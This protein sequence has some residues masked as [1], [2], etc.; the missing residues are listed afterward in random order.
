M[1]FNIKKLFF[2]WFLFLAVYL[3]SKL[4]FSIP[5]LFDYV[6]FSFLIAYLSFLFF[7]FLFLLTKSFIYSEKIKKIKI[8]WPSIVFALFFSFLFLFLVF[9]SSLYFRALIGN[10]LFLS[11]DLE[12]EVLNL[13]NGENFSI[14]SSFGVITNPFCSSDC[15]I[16][17]VD[18]NS[19]EK[20]F[21]EDKKFIFSSHEKQS[22]NLDFSDTKYG[23]RL[24]R[25]EFSCATKKNFLCH[26]KN[27]EEKFV[28]RV[29]V[30][31]H[32]LNDEQKVLFNDLNDTLYSLNEKYLFLSSILKNLNEIKS[33]SLNL[34]SN[35]LRIENFSKDLEQNNLS[36]ENYLFS[37][38]EFFLLEHSLTKKYSSLREI[39]IKI[40]ELNRSLNDEILKYNFL[41]NN[42][43]SVFDE[44]KE[45]S[46]SGVDFSSLSSLDSLIKS[47]NDSV[48]SFFNFSS[49][50]EKEKVFLDFYKFKQNLS[51]VYN[52]TNPAFSQNIL[53]EPNFTI[54]NFSLENYNFSFN[55]DSPKPLC[56]AFEKCV[57]CG[58][59]NSSSN[60]PVVF[61]HGHGFNSDVSVLSS[62][63][64]F[65]K[66]Q[67]ELEEYGY[68]N[69]GNFIYS[70]FDEE[71][72]GIFGNMNF[73]VTF[74]VSYYLLPNDDENFL[75]NPSLA[76]A[77]EY[78]IR[79]NKYIEKIKLLTG[80]D[81]VVLVSYSLGGLVS[82]RYLQ[83]F[84]EDSVDRLI[85]LA[86]PNYGVE[87][88][89]DKSC[90]I[91]GAD[92]ECKDLSFGSN[93]LEKL[94]SNV[95]PKIPVYNIL[96]E[97]CLLDGSPSDGIVKTKNSFL[98]FAV[99]R[100]FRG[101]CEGVNFLHE[102]V[103]DPDLIPEG[104]NLVKEFLE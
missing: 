7:I 23:Q 64:S 24:F 9:N 51:F 8:S 87:G 73:P 5:F 14:D 17:V 100:Y 22:F 101:S 94:N 92:K 83:I 47:F 61:V 90:S 48:S 75:F 89:V 95:S 66:F 29:V 72:Y 11:L 57:F 39:E 82:R 103:L 36:Y 67:R 77:E 102:K 19:G 70:D 1:K 35:I 12:K 52:Q 54:I 85:L 3:I 18:L 55:L 26:V 31:R 98:P 69:A 62:L 45:L 6:L 80:K 38:Q 104:F 59:S 4:F 50:E 79:L 10:D 2:F 71:Y 46:F 33:D 78:A 58:E 63:N 56:C 15:V 53:F 16:S 41:L 68:F 34:S 43:S 81:K 74:S 44:I 13:K 99:N 32:S 96:G 84:G 20:I 91:F 30:L 86:V 93:F 88:I 49:L 21:S 60:Y 76:G 97:G 25:V 42:F 65:N 37:N 28:S 40:L 27:T